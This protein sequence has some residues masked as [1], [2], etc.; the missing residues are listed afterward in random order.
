MVK[1]TILKRLYARVEVWV[2]KPNDK[3]LLELENVNE[4]DIEVLAKRK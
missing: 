3:A 2:F 4:L 1:V